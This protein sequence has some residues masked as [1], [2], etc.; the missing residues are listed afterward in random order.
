MGISSFPL[1]GGECCLI[2]EGSN[3]G[4]CVAFVI[5]STQVHFFVVSKWQ[6]SPGVFPPLFLPTSINSLL[7][8][9]HVTAEFGGLGYSHIFLNQYVVFSSEQFQKIDFSFG[10]REKYDLLLE[11]G[12]L[13]IFDRKG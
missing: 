2:L 9:C 7:F 11:L 5:P 13:H 8:F 10:K 6:F 4:I 12:K 3:E 1:T